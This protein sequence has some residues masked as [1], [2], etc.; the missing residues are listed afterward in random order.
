[1]Y[2][3]RDNLGRSWHVQL[4]AP[5]L[6]R[7]Q[8]MTGHDLRDGAAYARLT[9]EPAM[10]VRVLWCTCQPQADAAGVGPEDFGRS[11]AG[12]A[13]VGAAEALIAAA[14]ELFPPEVRRRYRRSV[15]T[16][17]GR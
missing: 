3:F 13:V 11:L 16:R 2:R 5:A 15:T 14:T 17:K 10:L 8:A 1:M 12:R 6:A 9:A 4:D 7:V